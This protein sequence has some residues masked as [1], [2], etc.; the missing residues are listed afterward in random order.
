[1]LKSFVKAAGKSHPTIHCAKVSDSLWSVYILSLIKVFLKGPNKLKKT[2]VTCVGRQ[3][4]SDI[5]VFNADTQ[6]DGNGH[7]IHHDDQQYYWY[8]VYLR[9]S[10]Y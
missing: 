9:N 7:L 8:K 4:N 6:V 5:W 3:P 2:L 10:K 1:M